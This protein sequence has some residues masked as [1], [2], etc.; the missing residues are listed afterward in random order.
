[1]QRLNC[2]FEQD[3]WS[4]FCKVKG[5]ITSGTYVKIYYSGFM[6]L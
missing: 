2:V 3:S 5:K 6:S 1:M 4:S